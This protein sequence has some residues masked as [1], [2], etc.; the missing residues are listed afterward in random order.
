MGRLHI[1]VLATVFVVLSLTQQSKSL[2]VM[3]ID[4]GSEWMKIAIVKPGV[5]M[6]IVLNKESRRKTPVVVSMKDDERLF[7]D[8]ALG[9]SVRYPK[10]AYFY[11]QDLLGKSFNN[12]IVKQYKQRFPFY[13]IIEDS[14]TGKPLFQH[15]EEH[16]YSPEELMSMI[17][18]KARDFAESYAE[19]PIK[20]VVITVPA[21]FNQAERR[22][23]MY[24]AKLSGLNVLQLIND[25]A[26]VALNYGVFRRQEFDKSIQHIIFY[27]MGAT[28]TTATIVG[29]KLAKTK[30]HGVSETNPHL[31]VKGVG[32][33]RGLGGLEIELRL[34]D[35]LVK[36]FTEKVK[37]K[38]DVRDSPRAMAKLLK[39][40]KRLKK[41][42]SANVDHLSQIEGV[43]E[44]K[45][46]RSMVT[47]AELE[48]MCADLWERVDDPINMALKSAEMGMN[49]ISQVILVGGGTRVPKVQEALL[50]ATG[51]S[52]LGKNINA[53]EA[54]AMG[55]VYQAAHLSKGFKVKK[56][57]VKDANLYPI[58]VDFTR[59]Q[60]DD[61]GV[62][63]NKKV[64]R[65][66][67]QRNNP[68][69]Q[70][71]VMT[72]NRMTDD[73][74]FHVNYAEL[75]TILP[76]GYMSVF[77]SANL[78]KV[79]LGG[80]AEKLEK[81]SGS[82]SKGIKAHFHMD[83]SGILNLVSVESV[84]EKMVDKP[85]NETGQSTFAK[86][87]SK[88]MD[89]FGGSKTEE[90]DG[91]V[92]DKPEETEEAAEEEKQT[93][94]NE[95]T[96]EEETK[97]ADETNEKADE[98][99]GEEQEE[100]NEAQNDEEDEKVKDEAQEEVVDD[101]NDDDSD[102]D[103]DA[104]EEE[105]EEVE[106]EEEKQEEPTEDETKPEATD[107]AEKTDSTDDSNDKKEDEEKSKE[108][109]DGGKEPEKEDK[110]DSKDEKSETD[111]K[112]K[113]KVKEVKPQL[114]TIK[115]NLTVTLEV[116]DAPK[117][118]EDTHKASVK[119]LKELKKKDEE[120]AKRE[121]AQNSLESFI[122]GMQDK[123]YQDDYISCST[124]EMREQISAS[125]SE[126]SDW[127]YDQEYDAPAKLFEDKLKNL[128]RATKK[129]EFR[130]E[131]KKRRPEAI[132]ALKDALNTSVYF[133]QAAKNLTGEDQYFTETEIGLLEKVYNETK[134]W[135][136]NA[137][138]EQKKTPLTE[139]PVLLIED[140]IQKINGLDR[141]LRYLSNKVKRT[142]TKK[143]KK[144]EKKTNTTRDGDEAT[145]ETTEDKA[146]EETVEEKKE[147]NEKAGENVEPEGGDNPKET[148]E[149]TPTP[150]SE[151]AVEDE[152]PEI[153]ELEAPAVEGEEDTSKKPLDN[154][155]QPPTEAPTED[156]T[157]KMKNDEL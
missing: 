36:L 101:D 59:L 52:E 66:L 12:S 95:E 23:L 38:G 34:R 120:K 29:Y 11:L 2:A 119:K 98:E 128:T 113:E 13:N 155:E 80:V 156:D 140:V 41:V 141:E 149:E 153:L 76:N 152:Q 81:N 125:L 144:K 48:E 103:D 74:A 91:K 137:L 122:Y 30:D 85:E 8:A 57:I 46:F 53:D 97:E 100:A 150:D 33:D 87:G 25:N 145:K 4:L 32:F 89:F 143:K 105:T 110:T 121:H 88:I 75:E 39:E 107:D 108:S 72:F 16:A 51:M 64:K 126:A 117:S 18:S 60:T 157:T 55:A 61:D 123:L 79:D 99:D 139:K 31:F 127:L 44:D 132:A 49:E 148:A 10:H 147:G 118:S 71:K 45:D 7:G 22:A 69:P 146:N 154:S 114:K 56:F 104:K 130:V 58:V 124:E 84:F 21:Y 135:F 20:D 106:K 111:T 142:A 1:A 15:D 62:T 43:L 65:T 129:L 28:S 67:F 47:R 138:K 83:E 42:L 35:H 134:E 54:A 94:T 131:E 115:E 24:A 40:A 109:T 86:L 102:D 26:A 17:L 5:P 151:G 77:G 50:K 27:D 78:S 9:V 68:Y 70:K 116:L 14:E 90:D 3:S 63:N 19:H 92:E 112:E 136:S 96:K 37:T 93:D 73:F 82:E 133:L 6:D